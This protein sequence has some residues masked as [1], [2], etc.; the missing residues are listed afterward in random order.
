MRPAWSSL[1]WPSG[2]ATQEIDGSDFPL[3]SITLYGCW[4]GEYWVLM[5]PSEY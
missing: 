5:L 1:R 2:L 4:D 3:P